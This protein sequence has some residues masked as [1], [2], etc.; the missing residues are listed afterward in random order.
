MIVR[1]YSKS[2]L[3]SLF[4]KLFFS[5]SEKALKQPYRKEFVAPGTSA[6]YAKSCAAFFE[7]VGYPPSTG[8]FGVCWD[9]SKITARAELDPRTGK[10]LNSVSF[11]TDLSFGTYA[12]YQKFQKEKVLAGYVMPILL[13]PLDPALSS[14]FRL[15]GLIPTNLKYTAFDLSSY[16]HVRRASGHTR[17]RT[18]PAASATPSHP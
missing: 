14:S 5:L 15:V 1:N 16:R 4:N 3:R 8:L 12:D 2:P 11:N 10:F 17:R 6:E 18:A 13:V 7:S 9:P